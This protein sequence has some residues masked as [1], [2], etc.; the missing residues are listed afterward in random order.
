MSKTNRYKNLTNYHANTARSVYDKTRVCNNIG[1]AS[2]L[3]NDALQDICDYAR[4][5]SI[6]IRYNI[7]T[8]YEYTVSV[9]L[10]GF[11]ERLNNFW[12]G[13]SNFK[14]IIVGSN[15]IS[16]VADNLRKLGYDVNI[17]SEGKPDRANIIL[18]INWKTVP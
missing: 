9:R 8:D 10:K 3:L 18:N 6:S 4:Y 1:N 5:G 16:Y 17:N 12:N 13:E 2:R 15:D 11:K 7:D 14:S